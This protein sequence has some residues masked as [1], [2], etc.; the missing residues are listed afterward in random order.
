MLGLS[1][2]PSEIDNVAL[3][4]IL[5]GL[6]AFLIS[7]GK[8][9]FGG[10]LALLG[11]PLMI[12]ACHGHTRLAMAIMLPLLIVNDYIAL[13]AWFRQWHWRPVLLLLPGMIVGIAAAWFIL[14]QIQHLETGLAETSQKTADAALMLGVGV[15]AVAYVVLQAVRSRRAEPIAFR[16]VFW[17]GSCVGAVA[18]LTST[19]GHVAGPIIRMYMLPQKMPKTRFVA[20]TLLYFWIG[21][22]IKLIPYGALGMLNADAWLGALVLLPAV[23]AGTATGVTLHRRVG[24]KQFT[25]FI[26]ALLLVSGLYFTVKASWQLWG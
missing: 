16:P 21:N 11:A 1:L 17:Q 9:G 4:L 7:V 24:Q 6:S 23:V 20:T 5:G 14:W 13:R 3:F 25:T 2:I 8:A 26:Y 10:G 15:I 19:L 12:V 22:Q 18:G